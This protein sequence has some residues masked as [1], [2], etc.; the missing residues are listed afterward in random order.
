MSHKVLRQVNRRK[1]KGPSVLYL[2]DYRGKMA[3]KKQFKLHRDKRYFRN[4][5]SAINQF[6]GY[7]WFPAVYEIKDNYI[8]YEYYCHCFYNLII[9]GGLSGEEKKRVLDIIISAIYDVYQKGYAH[10]D[11]HCKNV[12][13]NDSGDVKVI[14]WEFFAEREEGIDFMDSYDITGSGIKDGQIYAGSVYLF[15]NQF[16]FSIPRFFNM[17][18][19]AYVRSVINKRQ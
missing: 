18:D 11:I 17:L 5:V 2:A 8:L 3:I 6:E 1:T 15:D 10:R 4:E 14:D 19:L 9:G 12:L 7:D 13:L 16:K